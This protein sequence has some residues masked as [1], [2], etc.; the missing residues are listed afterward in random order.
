VPSDRAWTRLSTFLGRRGLRA[1]GRLNI[2]L[3]KLSG[4]RIGGRLSRAPILLLTTT[5]RK[6]GKQRT[7]PLV[8]LADGERLVVI[9][10]NAGNERPSAWALNLLEHPEAEV[11]VRR[12]QHAVRARV[13]EGAEREELWRRMNDQFGGFDIYRDRAGREIPLFVLEPK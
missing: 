11:Q 13:A 2:P 10:S 3:Y 6:S 7:C 12:E 8:Y 5:G 9:G 4:G 1:T